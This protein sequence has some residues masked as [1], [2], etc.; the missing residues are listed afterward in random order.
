MHST[1]TAALLLLVTA[2]ASACRATSAADRAA[3]PRVLVLATGADRMD[4]GEPTGLWLE[5]F[6]V[7]YLAFQDAGFAIEVATLDG[8]DVPIDAR[9]T[10]TE[11][12]AAAW[13]GT[14]PALRGTQALDDVDLRRFDAIFVPGGHGAMFDLARDERA[15][16]AISTMFRDGRVVA[17]VCHGPGALVNATDANGAPIVAGRRVS[18]FTDSEEYA[19]G[20][21]E[22][23]PFLL[24]TRMRE[25]GA[26][27]VAAPNFT[28]Q[29]VR[30]GNLV[31]G[32][33]PMSSAP[34][35]ALTIQAV[36]DAR[37]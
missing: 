34:A 11:E 18:I 13:R 19:V 8:G 36:R 15:A 7:P 16:R 2:A 31:T 5:E 20:L 6:A 1:L 29:A 9:S 3:P 26:D 33:N 35:A 37:K 25:L 12:Q 22:S 21:E 28:P 14:M 23:V 10:P 17:A 32:Q 30:D 27:V 24:E 4:D